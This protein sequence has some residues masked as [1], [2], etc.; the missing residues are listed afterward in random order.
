[1]MLPWIKQMGYPLVTVEQIIKDNKCIL[2]F[3]Q[4]RFLADGSKDTLNSQWQIPITIINKNNPLESKYKFLLKNFE[5][6]FILDNVEPNE[7]IK[8]Y[9]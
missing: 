5:D 9:I 4:S 8:V 2:K 1:M 3:K 6:E 7:W